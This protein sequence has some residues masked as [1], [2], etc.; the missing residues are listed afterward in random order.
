MGSF[1]Y[2]S[3]AVLGSKASFAVVAA[4]STTSCSSS[5]IWEFHCRKKITITKPPS[6]TPPTINKNS[7]HFISSFSFTWEIVLF[8]KK[9]CGFLLF[10][11]LHS[12]TLDPLHDMETSPA[13]GRRTE[14]A[15]PETPPSTNPRPLATD[16]PRGRRIPFAQR[17][18]AGFDQANIYL[19]QLPH[20]IRVC[21]F[22]DASKM[23]D[24]FGET[25]LLSFSQIP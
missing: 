4:A 20:Q 21:N 18:I 8:I 10:E 6:K 1:I 15:L 24:Q 14:L 7:L 2:R 12:Q 23:S 16:P 25:F 9:K 5:D 17:T 22:A 11:R 13:A 19:P 3:S